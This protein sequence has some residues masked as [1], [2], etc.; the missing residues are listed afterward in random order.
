[1]LH[2]MH[3]KE[4]KVKRG[5]ERWGGENRAELEGKVKGDGGRT[6]ERRGSSIFSRQLRPHAPILH[7]F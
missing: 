1:M 3:G 5:Q 7:R 2:G 6:E 4:G